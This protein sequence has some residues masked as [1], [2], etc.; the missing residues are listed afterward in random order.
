MMKFAQV[1]GAGL[2]VLMAAATPTLAADIPVKAAP[3]SASATAASFDWTGFYAGGTA[4]YGRGRSQICD[5]NDLICS[6]R[7][8][9]KGFVGG[10]TL[11]YNWQTSGWVLG[12]EGDISY[13]SVDGSTPGSS[14][15]G[16]NDEC[17][18]EVRQLATLRGRGGAT[19]D[20]LLLFVTGGLAMARLEARLLDAPPGSATKTGWTLG[21]G[22]EWAF[23][24]NW[25]AKLEYL[26]I[27]GLGEL[28]ADPTAECGGTGCVVPRSSFDVVRVG[29]N[30]RFATGKSPAPVAT[31]Y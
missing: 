30:Y 13:A 27:G 14:G 9:I 28:N 10:G 12:L 18:T 11:G 29:L 3:A 4:G 20:R 8:D 6:G 7:Y 31:R 15:F 17:R 26:H 23:A 16:C 21:A 2:L 5:P 25:S 19:F 22:L 24:P 1:T